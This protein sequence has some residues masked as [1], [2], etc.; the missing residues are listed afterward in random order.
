MKLDFV[1]D[2]FA[3]IE[4]F[5]GSE[6]GVKVKNFL[7]TGSV[8]TPTMVLA[9]LSDNYAKNELLTLWKKDLA[10]I[11]S[12]TIIIDLDAEIANKAGAF[13]AEIRNKLKNNFSLGDAIVYQTAQ[14]LGAKIVTGDYHFKNLQDVLFIEG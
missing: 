7:E 13:K 1:F 8:A 5:K 12:K 11:I 10:F 3:W 4:Y 14:K 2:S 6:Q 9:E